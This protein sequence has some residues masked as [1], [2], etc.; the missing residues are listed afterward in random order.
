MA[1]PTRPAEKQCDERRP[2]CRRCE[3]HGAPCPGY[4]RPLDIRFHGGPH[5]TV[6]SKPA[7]VH[8]A[9]SRHANIRQQQQQQHAKPS[10]GMAV[11]ALVSPTNSLSP[12]DGR[13]MGTPPTP[14]QVLPPPRTAWDDASL[15]YFLSEYCVAPQPGVMTGHLDFLPDLLFESSDDS[16]LRPAV[17]ASACLCFSR[18]KRNTELYARARDHYGKALMAVSTA[19]SKSP[20]SWGDDILAAIMLLHMFEVGSPHAMYIVHCTAYHGQGTMYPVPCTR[21]PNPQDKAMHNADTG[22]CRTWTV[23]LAAPPR[24]SR[25][26]PASTMRAARIC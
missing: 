12:V 4:D 7:P 15:C 18:N 16:S 1:D 10:H 19:I 20:D 26:L 3:L 9:N 13:S 14:L 25:A 24:T 17:L 6:L 8:H 2:G 11:S 21:L 5:A 23:S 22:A